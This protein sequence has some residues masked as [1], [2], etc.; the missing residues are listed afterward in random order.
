MYDIIE[1]GENN[2]NK[3]DNKKSA[4][5]SENGNK[6]NGGSE[7]GVFTCSGPIDIV[8]VNNDGGNVNGGLDEADCIAS[9]RN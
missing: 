2:F 6:A 5:I 9:Q 3:S 8:T 7:N 4:K 1:N